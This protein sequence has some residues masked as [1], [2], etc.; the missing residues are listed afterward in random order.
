SRLVK[1]GA[2]AVGGVAG[3]QPKNSESGARSWVLRTMVAGKH[4]DMGLGGYPDVTLAQAAK[5]R[6]RLKRHARCSSARCCR[7]RRDG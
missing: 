1:P 5:Q 3:L 6:A 7:Y 4:R 2:H